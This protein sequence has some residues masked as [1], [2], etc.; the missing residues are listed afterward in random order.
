MIKSRKFRKRKSLGEP[1]EG[2]SSENDNKI[3]KSYTKSQIKVSSVAIRK[4]TQFLTT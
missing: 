4:I 3:G 2:K 1:P